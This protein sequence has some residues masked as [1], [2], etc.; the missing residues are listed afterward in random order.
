MPTY[1]AVSMEAQLVLQG[2]LRTEW[3]FRES[4]VVVK[5]L[6]LGACVLVYHGM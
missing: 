3:H 6:G 4:G 5:G 1:D 2:V